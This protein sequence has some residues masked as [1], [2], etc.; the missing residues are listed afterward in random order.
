MK[1]AIRN[2]R[3]LVAPVCLL[4]FCLA[5]TAEAGDSIPVNGQAIFTDGH[6][7]TWNGNDL[8]LSVITGVVNNPFAQVGP[9][10]PQSRIPRDQLDA[11]GNRLLPSELFGFGFALDFDPMSVLWLAHIASFLGDVN[12]G[13][14]FIGNN[15]GPLVDVVRTG[16]VDKLSDPLEL[17]RHQ[18]V[19]VFGSEKVKLDL[20]HEFFQIADSYFMSFSVNASGQAASFGFNN[21]SFQ[22]TPATV[23]EPSTLLLLGTGLIGVG[24]RRYR[25][26]P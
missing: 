6:G 7:A 21:V 17:D 18:E 22:T 3:P 26:K 8:T 2:C 11:F 25:R 9:D 12:T 23:P 13:V 1:N 5:P 20:D 4:F 19:Y 16:Y 15:I 14:V 10:F 24:V